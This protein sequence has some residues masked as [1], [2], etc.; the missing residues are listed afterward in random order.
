MPKPDAVNNP[1]G[2]APEG[3]GGTGEQQSIPYARFKE[4]NDG[5]QSYKQYGYSPED[6]KVL[7]DTGMSLDDIR[8][9]KELDLKPSEVVE[10]IQLLEVLATQA[11]ANSG[12]AGAQG[13]SSGG[14][15]QS[16][17]EDQQFKERMLKA[18]PELNE[19][20]KVPQTLKE[21][22]EVQRR[23]E[24]E[25]QQAWADKGKGRLKELATKAGYKDDNVEQLEVVLAA[26]ISKDESLHRQWAVDPA[27]V[28]ET[29]FNSYQDSLVKPVAR[30]QAAG[31]RGVKRRNQEELAPRVSGG[32]A[33]EGG[34]KPP[35]KPKNLEEAR[36][37]AENFLKESGAEFPLEE[38]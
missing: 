30:A 29:A 10:M 19:A 20:L 15:D 26:L 21:Q 18:F 3:E 37:V 12:Q 25:R 16:S 11:Q 32:A 28:V 5:Y 24:V 22:Q 36:S 35:E 4:V 34:G 8:A 31:T 13:G 1:S 38:E 14:S 9:F 33:P 7:K 2:S 27:G 6:I 23:A 17:P